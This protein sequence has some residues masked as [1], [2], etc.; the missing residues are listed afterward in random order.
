[1]RRTALTLILLILPTL[2]TLLLWGPLVHAQDSVFPLPADLY[3]LTSEHRLVRID[4]ASGAQTAL[5]SDEQRVADFDISPDGEWLLYRTVGGTNM[6][7]ITALDGLSGYVVEFLDSEPPASSQRQTIGWSPDAGAVAYII[8]GGVR[9][10]ERGAGEYGSAV[11][12]TVQGPWT[13]FVW[14]DS[15]TLLALDQSG[16][17]TRISGQDGQFSLENVPA[18]TV[19]PAQP[20]PSELTPAGVVLADGRTVPGTAGVLAFRWSPLL[21]DAA[22]SFAAPPVAL[23]IASLPAILYYLAPD[24]AGIDQVWRLGPAQDAVAAQGAMNVALTAEASPVRTY[25]VSPDASRI[26]YVVDNTLVAARLDGSDRRPVAVLALE[27]MQPSVAWRPDG[28]QVAYNDDQGLWLAALDGSQPRLLVENRRTLESGPAGFRV[29]TT[30]RW[31]DDGSRLLVTIGL[32]EGSYLGVVDAATGEVIEF[33]GVGASRGRWTG[34][35]RVM[36]WAASWG[37]QTPGLFLLDP[38]NPTLPPQTLLDARHPV[39]DMAPGADGA[40]FALVTTTAEMGPQFVRVMRAPS[41]G[42]PF[43]RAYP[44]GVGGFAQQAYLAA[45]GTAAAGLYD[46]DWGSA[47]TPAGDLVIIHFETGDTIQVPASGPV[48]GLAW[49]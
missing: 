32:Y 35:G 47:G 45:G 3:I 9:I 14:E 15:H 5:L 39:I 36:A 22:T 43:E 25:A 33:S 24:S 4:A 38:A 8:P 37:Y 13:E 44:E 19:E 12:T 2:S 49:Q 29:Y 48:H 42:A 23:P 41:L 6:A 1:M 7:I 30:P 10:V 27:N 46:V 18:A 16:G 20:V 11:L 26:A 21:G 17:G 28:A 34:D 40:W 31:N